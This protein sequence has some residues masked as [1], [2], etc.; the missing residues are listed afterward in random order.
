[1]VNINDENINITA[2][3]DS[4]HLMIAKIIFLLV[5]ADQ[6]QFKMSSYS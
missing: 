2:L 4:A 6:V 3:F 5:N 1:M